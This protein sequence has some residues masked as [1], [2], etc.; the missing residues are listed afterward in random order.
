MIVFWYCWIS[1]FFF[2]KILWFDPLFRLFYIGIYHNSNKVLQS[3]VYFIDVVL[4]YDEFSLLKLSLIFE[5]VLLKKKK[6]L[7]VILM[8]LLL[9]QLYLLLCFIY[10]TEQKFDWNCCFCRSD[11][12][13]SP[14]HR[15]EVYC[16]N[17]PVQATHLPCWHFPGVCVGFS[18]YDYVFRLC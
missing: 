7:K 4:K 17:W 13:E 9:N 16:F 2:C 3:Y 15:A 6:M 18:A 11:S 5:N 10:K 12:S 14:H 8:T 1:N